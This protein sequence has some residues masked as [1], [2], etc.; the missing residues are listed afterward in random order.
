SII[1]LVSML[2]LVGLF[3]FGKNVNGATAW[4]AIGGMTIQPSEF[5]KFATALAVAKY[6]SDLQTNIHEFKHQL[7]VSLILLI[8]AILIALQPDAG[9]ALVYG[10]FFFVFYR[11]G[12]PQ[13]YLTIGFILLLLAISSLKFLPIP[14]LLVSTVL[15]FL[16]Y[17]FIRHKRQKI[18]HPSLL[19]LAF[20]CISFGVRYFY[21][22]II[23]SHQ[24]D[25]IT[26]W[27]RLE[28]DPIVLEK[29]KQS[30]S[31]NLNESEKAI[32]SGGLRS[33][34]RR[35]GKDCRFVLR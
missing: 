30:I 32:S 17:F 13:I 1:Y 28:K 15:V 12:I 19:V 33:E 21:T 14:T 16:H 3:F 7:R 29:M 25:R 6:I 9:S 5:A 10:S 34:E 20:A 11:E 18:Y 23:P 8:P 2:S 27:L 35:V 4:Y 26:I 31:Y 24:R 22:D